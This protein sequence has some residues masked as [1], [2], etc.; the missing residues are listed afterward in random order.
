M[1]TVK[2]NANTTPQTL[3]TTPKHEKGKLTAVIVDNQSTSKKT[4][5]IQDVFTPDS[6]AGNPSPTTQTIDR[7]QLTVGAGLTA[8][9]DK[10]SLEGV[11]FLGT[12]QAV[13]DATDTACV[14]IVVYRFE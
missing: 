6:T 2:V 4:I 14:I 8:T 11:E 9:L 5:K 10:L 7:V 3:F 1:P 13:A 12:A